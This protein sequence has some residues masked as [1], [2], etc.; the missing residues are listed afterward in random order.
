MRE[1]F[2]SNLVSTL[3]LLVLEPV[4]MK[5]ADIEAEAFIKSEAEKGVKNDYSRS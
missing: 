1:S 2:I 5:Y 4:F 3:I